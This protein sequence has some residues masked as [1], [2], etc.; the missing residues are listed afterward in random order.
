MNW[1]LFLGRFH[2]LLVHL[3]IGILILACLFDWI[4]FKEKFHSLKSAVEISLLIG[5]VTACLSCITGYLLSQSGEYDKNTVGLHQWLGILTMLFSFAYWWIKRQ[6]VSGKISKTLS[7]ITLLLLTATGHLGGTLTHGEDYL[8]GIFS[9]NNRG[10][11]FSSLNL[12]EALYYK[13]VVQPILKARCYSCHAEAKQKGKLRLDEPEFILKGGKNGKVLISAHPDESELI[14]RLLLPLDDKK[15]MPPKEKQQLSLTEIELLKNWIALGADFSKSI[16]ELD[17]EKLV[18]NIFKNKS[19]EAN[20]EVNELNESVASVEETTLQKLRK[21]NATVVPIAEGN[22]HLSITLI[23]STVMDSVFLLLPALRDQLVWLYANSSE[24]N[25]GH[26][27]SI[28]QLAALRKLDLRNSQLTDNGILK[29]KAL[30]NLTHL[31][32]SETQVGLNG[33]K[34][35]ASLPKLRQLFLYRTNVNEAQADQLKKDFPA[36]HFETGNYS[37]STLSTD[38]TLVKQSK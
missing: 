7:I 29:L 27:A 28:A 17:R 14:N 9:E 3:P 6:N 32:L 31:N 26:A 25:D 20:D 8:S 34:S 36:V 37:V 18:Q 1:L 4:S 12:N 22:H 10:L 21:W 13:D 23:N 15:H 2:P 33:I 5:A 38:T 35:I 19:S 16:K 24:V 30:N 11:D